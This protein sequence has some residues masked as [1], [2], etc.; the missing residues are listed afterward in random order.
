MSEC[1]TELI[2]D[3]NYKKEALRTAIQAHDHEDEIAQLRIEWV[4]A[5]A[6]VLAAQKEQEKSETT[7]RY[8]DLPREPI[9]EE[10]EEAFLDGKFKWYLSSVLDDAYAAGRAQAMA[11]NEDGAISTEMRQRLLSELA[12]RLKRR[13]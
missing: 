2:A 12:K 3:A 7:Q 11:L 9:I 13:I 8:I 4:D 1:I 5:R 6:L 10:N